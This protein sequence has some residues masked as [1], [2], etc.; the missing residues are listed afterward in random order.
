M[1]Q[2]TRILTQQLLYNSIYTYMDMT[3]NYPAGHNNGRISQSVDRALGET[4]GRNS[5]TDG[6]FPFPMTAHTTC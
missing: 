4:V 6:S 1:M 5:G 3:Y 2:L